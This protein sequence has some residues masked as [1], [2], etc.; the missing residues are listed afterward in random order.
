MRRNRERMLRFGGARQR[1]ACPGRCEAEMGLG[2]AVA[3]RPDCGA[4]GR[5]EYG[6]KPSGACRLTHRAFRGSV[7]RGF[8]LR[9]EGR[10][11]TFPQGS[12]GCRGGRFSEDSAYP[13]LGL[14]S[15]EPDDLR[16][17]GPWRRAADIRSESGFRI[18]QPKWRGCTGAECRIPRE[19]REGRKLSAQRRFCRDF[20]RHGR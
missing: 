12:A 7:R 17:F 20:G 18:P 10:V 9:R 5:T 13:F 3:D 19:E 16:G 11:F 15:A 2:R 8:R 6:V 14:L 4:R 1:R